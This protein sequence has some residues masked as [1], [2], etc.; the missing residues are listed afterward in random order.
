[1]PSFVQ[2]QKRIRNLQLPKENYLIYHQKN[3]LLTI[4]F[5]LLE[6]RLASGAYLGIQNLL[7]LLQ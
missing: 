6:K 4:L 7:V 1:M 5:S 2:I 3:V